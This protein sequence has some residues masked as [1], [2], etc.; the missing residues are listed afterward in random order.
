MKFRTHQQRE[1]YFALMIDTLI[2]GNIE[3]FKT[4]LQP[5]SKSELCY[6]IT[7][8]AGHT[9]ESIENSYLTISKFLIP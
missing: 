5:L 8:F 2:S 9:G 3:D 4:A 6:L 1:R 7:T